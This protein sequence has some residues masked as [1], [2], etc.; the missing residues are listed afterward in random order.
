MR[1]TNLSGAGYTVDSTLIT[2]LKDIAVSPANALRRAGL[3]DDLLQ[4]APVRLTP[5]D[6]YALWAGIEQESGDPLL[7]VRLGQAIRAESFSPPLFAAL[8]SPNLQVAAQR[9]ARYKA[10]VA[11]MRMAAVEAGDLLSVE[12][13]WLDEGSPPPCRW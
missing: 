3:A 12:L 2:L 1:S 4:H 8:C 9:I 11:P 10:I 13:R 7:A 6:Y 5:S